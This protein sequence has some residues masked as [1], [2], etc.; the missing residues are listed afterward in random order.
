MCD[1][2][3]EEAREERCSL[4]AEDMEEAKKRVKNEKVLRRRDN[5]A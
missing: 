1:G 5:K 2:M 4:K 3:K